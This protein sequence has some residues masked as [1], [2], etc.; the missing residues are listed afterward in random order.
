LGEIVRRCAQ[1]IAARHSAGVGAST[2]SVFLAS[3]GASYMTGQVLHP[4]GGEV[5]NG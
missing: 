1:V 2:R 3:E 4:N 5:T